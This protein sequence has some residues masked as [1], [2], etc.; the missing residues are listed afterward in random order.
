[1]FH[2]HPL[3]NSFFNPFSIFHHTNSPI[4][5]IKSTLSFNKTS[6]SFW[7]ISNTNEKKPCLKASYS[8]LKQVYMKML[9]SA[10]QNLLINDLLYWFEISILHCFHYSCCTFSYT[11]PFRSLTTKIKSTDNL[12][13]L[14]RYK[15]F[16]PNIRH[17]RES[18]IHNKKIIHNYIF[19]IFWTSIWFV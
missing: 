3:K 12:H 7:I 13:I 14:Y 5:L 15:L 11:I 8:R 6:D 2:F 18:N 19:F 1:M 9:I 16:L 4:W 17:K 10:K